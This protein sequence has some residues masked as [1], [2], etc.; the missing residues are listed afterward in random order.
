METVRRCLFGDLLD[1]VGGEGDYSLRSPIV[2]FVS[3]TPLGLP[4]IQDREHHQ[5]GEGVTW[6]LEGSY[7]RGER[8]KRGTSTFSS[9]SVD[10][11][12]R[13]RFADCRERKKMKT[14]VNESGRERDLI[15]KI[16]REYIGIN[17]HDNKSHPTGGDGKKKSTKRG[18][19]KG[20]RDWMIGGRYTREE[21]ISTPWV[22]AGLPSRSISAL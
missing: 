7:L 17:Q 11:N 13:Y 10:N 19:L 18:T 12:T 4:E 3:S 5:P 15:R 22:I 6:Q 21:P 8:K 2:V 1:E 14:T 9:S 20:E 16:T